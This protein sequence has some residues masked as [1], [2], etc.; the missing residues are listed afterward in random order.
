MHINLDF[1][2]PTRMAVAC[3]IN[4][5]YTWE[6][7]VLVLS[8]SIKQVI[9]FEILQVCTNKMRG[10]VWSGQ[11]R[12]RGG[13]EENG[14]TCQL[15]G[16]K[17]TI[18]ILSWQFSGKKGGGQSKNWWFPK[19]FTSV[20]FILFSF[21]LLEG[22]WKYFPFSSSS[23]SSLS[24][25]RSTWHINDSILPT[26]RERERERKRFSF[27]SWRREKKTTVVIYA[28]PGRRRSL[29]HSALLIHTVKLAKKNWQTLSKFWEKN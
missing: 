22:W 10:H 15:V 13:G 27:D 24:I 14:Q 23:S 18:K 21:P 11:S 12:K 4:V 5:S 9:M 17:K 2:P 28:L 16:Q 20:F 8:R 6:K 7:Q 1:S 19:Y 26:Q 29:I 3:L 25:S